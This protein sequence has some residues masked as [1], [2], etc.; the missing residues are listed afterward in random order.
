MSRMRRIACAVLIAIPMAVAAAINLD[1]FDTN[2]MRD[3]DDAHKDLEPVLGA[4]N[5]A[6]AAEDLTVL[7]D[8]YSWTLEFFTAQRTEAPDAVEIA[9]AGARLLAEIESATA[10]RNFDGAVAKARELNANCKS[11]HE[12]YKPKKR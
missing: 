9:T 4:S 7:K 12:K 8:G 5:V 11:C 1:E 2:V 10:A 3:M 6:A